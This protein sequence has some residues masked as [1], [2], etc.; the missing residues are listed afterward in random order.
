MEYN[1]LTNELSQNFIEYAAAVNTDRAIPDATS[2]LKPV[3]RRILFGAFDGGRTSNKPYVK[4]A[5]IV[6]D[7][8]GS[9][10]PHG[11]SSIYGALVRLSQP[12]IMRY[13]LIDFYGNQG[14]IGGDGPAAM[15]YTES[16][17]MKLTEE[18][19]LSG[20]KKNSVDFIPNFDD[21]KLEPITFP[22]F[23]PNLLCNPNSGIG[24]ALACNW[25]PHN[26]NEVADAIN[27]HIDGEEITFLAPDFP[28]GGIIINKKDI[29]NIVKTGHGSVKVRARY[30]VEKQNIIFYEIPYGTNTEALLG[31]IGKLAEDE[32]TD[33]KD[34]RNES[35]KKGIRIVVECAKTINP[36]IIVKKLF[37][38]T[39]LQTSISYNQVALIDKTPTDM[40]LKDCLDIYVSHNTKCI[41]R[42]ARFDL[43]KALA[44]LEIVNGLLKALEDIDNI[45]ALIKSSESSKDAKE[46]L[47]AKYDFTEN[48]AKAILDMKLAKLAKLESIELNQEKN[49]LNTKIEELDALVN[50]YSL[51]IAEL[52]KRLDAIVKKYGDARRT[53][54]MDLEIPKEEKE[55]AAVIPEKCVVVMTESGLIKRI[56]A[57]S[58]RTQKRNGK[59]I[60]TQDDITNVIIRTNTVDNIMIFSNKGKMYRLLVDNIPIGTN[61]SQGV[62]IHSLITMENDEKPTT[63][64]SI[65][66]D[67][68]AKY[69]LFITKN[70]LVKRTALEEYTKTKKKSGINA[71][72]IKE[73]DD[74]ACVSLI[75][76]EPLILITNSGMA[77]KFNSSEIGASGRTS[78]G[79]KGITLKENDYVVSGLPIRHDSDK[80]AIFS[81]L[82]LAKKIEL[83][84]FPIQKRAGKG[85]ICYKP[86]NQTGNVVGAALVDNEDKILVCGDKSSICIAASEIPSQNRISIGN[87]VIK[88][89][90]VSGVSKV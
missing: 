80:I 15:R 14:N 47:I 41:E 77:I 6:G 25:L 45:I 30:R 58:F 57:S 17:L 55:I 83:K 69:V 19:M 86:T 29:P 89:S 7:V 60:K 44:R 76:D 18:G 27:K 38:K 53:D 36:E 8:M 63:I 4:C 26:L 66:R 43:E 32:L 84:E 64:Y 81:E 88:G 74:L 23:F 68:D 62:S 22:S 59:G 73:D 28:T 90:K 13:P 48:Q 11:D 82:G 39:N 79:V 9:L 72:S 21:T 70:G 65:Y 10:H 3:A 67:T 46:K 31:E 78:M 42:E 24:V 1:N 71:I 51:Q 50:T 5:R 85:L 56:P 52:R 37:L 61:A 87:Q 12:W 2:G 20:L 54:V 34:I 75:K 33:I 40:N 49:D 16:R 35:N